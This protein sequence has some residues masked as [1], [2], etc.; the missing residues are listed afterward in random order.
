M[1][2]WEILCAIAKSTD[3]SK[4]VLSLKETDKN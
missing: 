1:S 3:T 2:T 4:S